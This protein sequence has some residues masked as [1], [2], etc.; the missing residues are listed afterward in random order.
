MAAKSTNLSTMVIFF[1]ICIL[2]L[3][4]SPLV[5]SFEN[6]YISSPTESPSSADMLSIEFER[7]VTKCGENLS[8]NCGREIRN[9]LLGIA[10]VSGYCCGQLVEMGLICHK[11]MVRLASSITDNEKE[12][13]TITSNSARVYNRCAKII[14]SSAPSTKY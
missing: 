2:T 9:D 13:S 1:A 7:F 12:A 6:E 3:T 8:N 11:G 5:F 4:P 10:E 14:S